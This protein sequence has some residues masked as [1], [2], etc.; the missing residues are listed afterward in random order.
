[1]TRKPPVINRMAVLCRNPI[2][3]KNKY[4]DVTNIN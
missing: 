3:M 4:N 1:M 2:F